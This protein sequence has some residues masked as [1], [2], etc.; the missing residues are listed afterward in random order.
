MLMVDP[1]PYSPSLLSLA[2]I[3]YFHLAVEQ[4]SYY[5]NII[6][7]WREPFYCDATTVNV[8]SGPVGS[9]LTHWCPSSHS[10]SSPVWLKESLN[11]TTN[12]KNYNLNFLAT[13]QPECRNSFYL[14]R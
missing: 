7:E 6:Q 8:H 13:G 4:M 9:W 12:I 14:D 10:P 2:F 11:L 1:Q 3:M 5:N